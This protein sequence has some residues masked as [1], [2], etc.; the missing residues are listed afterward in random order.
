ME[1]WFTLL[2][3]IIAISSLYLIPHSSAL[4]PP[5]SCQESKRKGFFV[6]FM[7]VVPSSSYEWPT[8]MDH[9]KGI[10]P[11][12]WN[13]NLLGRRASPPQTTQLM[14]RLSSV[15]MPGLF[16]YS[17]VWSFVYVVNFHFLESFG[18]GNLFSTALEIQIYFS[19]SV[20]CSK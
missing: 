4:D 17:S 8:P 9:L 10:S 5:L 11:C 7:H 14:T 6:F 20:L 1:V 18:K 13:S 15:C 19:Y 3:M 12:V 16:V 2:E